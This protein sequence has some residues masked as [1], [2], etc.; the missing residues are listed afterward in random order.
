M[1]INIYAELTT[2]TSNK[3][4][5]VQVVIMDVY[6]KQVGVLVDAPIH[7][8]I[9]TPTQQVTVNENPLTAVVIEQD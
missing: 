3:S 7:I 5:D 4:K 9:D 8:S 1:E 6:E 2:S